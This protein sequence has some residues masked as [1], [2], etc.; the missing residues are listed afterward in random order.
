[1]KISNHMKLRK[2]VMYVKKNLVLIKNTLKSEIIVII[3]GNIGELPI[4][5]AIYD[6]K[7]RGR[8]L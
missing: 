6:I 3:L 1:M 8:F 2:F 5:F 7:Y 4:V